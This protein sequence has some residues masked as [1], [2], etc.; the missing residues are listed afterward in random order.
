MIQFQKICLKNFLSHEDTELVFPKKGILPVFGSNGEGKSALFEAIVWCLFGKSIR[1]ISADEVIMWGKSWCSVELKFK[2]YDNVYKIIRYRKHSKYKNQVLI[3]ENKEDKPKYFCSVNEAQKFIESVMGVNYIIFLNSVYFGQNWNKFFVSVDLS[4]R[5]K[6]LESF[7]GADIFRKIYKKAS[8]FLKETNMKLDNVR[9]KKDTLVTSIDSLKSQKQTMQG[10]LKNIS[11]DIKNKQKKLRNEFKKLNDSYK[12]IKENIQKLK[13]KKKKLRTKMFKLQKNRYFL[14]KEELE[15]LRNK[16][17]KCSVIIRQEEKAIKY[18]KNIDLSDECTM[19]LR[20]L[21]KKDLKIYAQKSKKE[22]E[23]SEDIIKKERQKVKK[24]EQ[25]ETEALDLW[26]TIDVIKENIISIESYIDKKKFNLE[27][28]KDKI[29]N[30]KEEFNNITKNSKKKELVKEINSINKKIRNR[31]RELNKIKEQENDL[32]E[33]EEALIFWKNAFGSKGI[34]N[35]VLSNLR[36][37]LNRKLQEFA[38]KLLENKFILEFTSDN[39]NLSLNVIKDG[40]VINFKSLSGGER[41]RVNLCIFLAISEWKL[42][43][44]PCSFSIFDEPFVFVDS[45]GMISFKEILKELAKNKCIFLVSH[46][47]NQLEFD[48]A[49]KII[50]QMENKISKIDYIER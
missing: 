18:R 10:L 14:S 37:F 21:S 8:D 38:L 31:Q 26:E 12:S 34:I 7:V 2:K 30:I 16:K 48:S 32:K 40:K 20:P 11:K 5:R 27:H 28:I 23:K 22:I 36:L 25:L 35:M 24:L 42:A 49:K 46:R 44:N 15:E 13:E 29:I 50:I 19:C 39:N 3:F 17:T 33:T 47:N 6:L 4:E 41:Q 9:Y 43:N 45:E 1:G